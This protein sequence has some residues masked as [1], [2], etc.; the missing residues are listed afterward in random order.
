CQTNTHRYGYKKGVYNF[1]DSDFWHYIQ[2]KDG[3]DYKAFNAKMEAFSQRH[4]EGNKVSGSVEKFYLQPLLKAHLY[5]DTEYEIAQTGSATV[6]WGLLVTALFIIGIAWVNYINLATARSV[7]R[8][9]EVGVRKVL[10][11]AR[12]NLVG[13]FMLENIL[14]NIT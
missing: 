2:L 9:K 14:L 5:S 8:A 7:E 12:Q 1:T 3:T 10:G 13:Q 11:A 4:F 6:V